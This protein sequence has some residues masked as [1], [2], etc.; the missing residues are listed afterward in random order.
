MVVSYVITLS[1]VQFSSVQYSVQFSLD[2]LVPCRR[3]VVVIVLLETVLL[4]LVSEGRARKTKTRAWG[5][6]IACR[7][8]EC[9][10]AS[11]G[12]G[13][14]RRRPRPRQ[15]GEGSP[16]GSSARKS[17][18]M[19]HAEGQARRERKRERGGDDQGR[20]TM[21]DDHEFILTCM[22]APFQRRF[23]IWWRGVQLYWVSYY[24]VAGCC[25]ACRTGRS[26]APYRV[27]HGVGIRHHVVVQTTDH[28]PQAQGQRQRCLSTAA[29]A[30]APRHRDVRAEGT[31]VLERCDWAAQKNSDLAPQK[32]GNRERDREREVCQRKMWTD[33]FQQGGGGCGKR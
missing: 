2:F 15:G 5:R 9:A 23:L 4:V 14:G 13:G 12:L 24:L 17:S 32:K 16:P 8:P 6:G 3:L 22:H 11:S 28:L 7:K 26:R 29:A 10:S 25:G 19:E 18:S 1:L 33:G 20:W 31:G 27:E 21:D 30:L